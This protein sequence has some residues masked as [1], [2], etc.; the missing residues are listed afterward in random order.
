MEGTGFGRDCEAWIR[1]G[2]AVEGLG[3]WGDELVEV[4]WD[5]GVLNSG[6]VSGF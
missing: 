6:L 5:G 1:N 4:S 3:N 2:Q